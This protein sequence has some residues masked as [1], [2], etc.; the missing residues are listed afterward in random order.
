MS[1]DQGAEPGER[2]ALT[3]SQVG[4]SDQS[5]LSPKGGQNAD[6]GQ[7]TPGCQELCKGGQLGLAEPR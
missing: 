6:T 4:V 1:W 5:S 2:W 7:N 3:R